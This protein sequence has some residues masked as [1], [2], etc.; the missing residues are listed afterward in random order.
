MKRRAFIF[1]CAASLLG[2]VPL[3][4]RALASSKASKRKG[5]P[6]HAPA[7]GYR[8]KTK[9]GVEIEFDSGLGVHVV[10]GIPDHYFF[11]D[12]YYRYQDGSWQVSARFDNAWISI[13]DSKLPSGLQT[14][15]GHYKYKQKHSKGHKFSKI[16]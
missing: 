2:S 14:K 1:A 9:H 8:R 7:H 4:S 3:A 11:D 5:P 13:S 10:V 12:L 16:K 15:A 6:A